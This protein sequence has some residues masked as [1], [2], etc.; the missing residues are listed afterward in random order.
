MQVNTAMWMWQ[1]YCEC[2]VNSMVISLN[3]T[4]Y[5]IPDRPSFYSHRNYAK[6]CIGAKARGQSDAAW[7]ACITIA[8]G[9]RISTA[10]RTDFPQGSAPWEKYNHFLMRERREFPFFT[11]YT[12]TAY[13]LFFHAY[14]FFL[15][16][17][18]YFRSC[19]KEDF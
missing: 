16:I 17:H 12:Q 11:R 19:A 14:I 18:I 5:W 9:G 10:N 2:C 3:W 15:Y 4:A 8:A 7:K 1:R 6:R 13:I